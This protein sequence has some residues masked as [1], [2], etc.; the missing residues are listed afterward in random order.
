ME[1]RLCNQQHGFRWGRSVST[2]LLNLS[3]AT[4]ESF[5]RRKQLDVFY[6][7]FQTAFDRVCHRLLIQ[8][9]FRFGIGGKTVRWVS[10]FIRDRCNYVEICGTR[11]RNFISYSGVGAG[12]TLG[13]MLFLIFINDIHRSIRYSEFLLFAD[14]IKLF[15]EVGTKSDTLKLQ[16]DIDNVYKW[17]HDN[18]LYFNI[19]KCNI[20][21]LHRTSSTIEN[22]YTLNGQV[23]TRVDEVRDLGVTIDAR[24]KFTIHIQKII[25]AA[26]QT[27]GFIKRISSE[28]FDRSVLRLLFTA[29]VRS[30]LEFGSVIWDPYQQIYRNEIESV[31]KGFLI[32]LLGDEHRS[33]FRM[34]PYHERARLVDLP[35]LSSRRLEMKIMMGHDILRGLI[36]D[37]GLDSKLV[38]HRPNRRLRSARLLDETVYQSDYLH[39][40]PIAWII[41]LLNQNA[42]LYLNSNS[43]SDFRAA[44]RR[45][46]YFSNE[47]D[48]QN[49]EL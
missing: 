24:F 4:N 8:K 14:D 15:V 21:T 7:D 17:C 40:Q 13:P 47:D 29:Y 19:S 12:T 38:L 20:I 30:K 11:S 32:Y 43:K 46:L 27:I 44:I 23:I 25:S 49:N 9:L 3:I 39:W 5:A 48:E 33:Q 37:S 31:Q 41:R 36:R 45:S 42:D 26:R 1:S 16:H 6:G 34:A 35:S 18:R 22:N 2:N 28:R 10:S